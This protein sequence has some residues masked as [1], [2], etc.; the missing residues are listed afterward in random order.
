MAAGW[1][2]AK[3]A[4]GKD[5]ETV[6]IPKLLTG[7]ALTWLLLVIVMLSLPQ[8]GAGWMGAV[9][10]SVTGSVGLVFFLRREKQKESVPT[11]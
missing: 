6:R 10:M 1:G 5:R 11:I 9:A 4:I 2:Q 8:A 7:A 3:R